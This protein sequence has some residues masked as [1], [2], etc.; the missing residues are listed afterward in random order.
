MSA[1]PDPELLEKLR[2]IERLHAGATT[3]GERAAAADAL[4]RITR[5]LHEMQ[6][7]EPAVEHRFRLTDDWSKK[8]FIALLRRY[9]L[10]PYRYARQRRLTVMVRAPRSF[11]D[12]TLWPEF[13]DLSATLKI[14]LDGLTEQI[15]RRGIH[16][17]VADEEVIRDGC[18]L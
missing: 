6:A 12:E 11:V 14:H 4:K 3:A 2:K 9:S 16:E 18:L 10:K 7:K 13:L 1:E 5:K 17:D 8:L 15:I